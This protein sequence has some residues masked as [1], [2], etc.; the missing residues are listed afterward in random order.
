MS[1]RS[2]IFWPQGENRICP[3][4][5]AVFKKLT[6]GCLHSKYFGQTLTKKSSKKLT[7]VDR[8]KKSRQMRAMKT[9]RRGFQPSGGWPAPAPPSP[10]HPT[11][12]SQSSKVN[13]FSSKFFSSKLT[14]SNAM[15]S[16]IT[17]SVYP[18]HRPSWIEPL[19]SSWQ[20]RSNDNIWLCKTTHWYLAN[21]FLA[22]TA[23]PP[24]WQAIKTY[25]VCYQ[26]FLGFLEPFWLG[27]QRANKQS[28]DRVWLFGDLLWPA[29]WLWYQ[30]PSN[31]KSGWIWP[32]RIKWADCVGDPCGI[33]PPRVNWADRGGIRW[34][35]VRRPLPP[36]PAPPSSNAPKL[37]PSGQRSCTK[38][39]LAATIT[40]CFFRFA[41][42]SWKLK[43]S[44]SQRP[45]LVQAFKDKMYPVLNQQ[46]IQSIQIPGSLKCWQRWWWNW[47]CNNGDCL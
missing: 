24:R 31:Y 15:R 38:P 42:N 46:T 12:P 43:K 30:R 8:S 5:L 44:V 19:I 20:V 9:W 27:P 17:S 45:K 25:F 21:H 13:S 3:T 39:L 41:E 7:C 47:W 26:W 33:Q 40:E 14:S 10:S 1:Q 6:K 29:I 16:F 28:W 11:C 2:I 36:A 4:R 35:G 32:P 37:Q 18:N 23:R 22:H 34:L